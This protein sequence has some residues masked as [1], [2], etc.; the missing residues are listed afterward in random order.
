MLCVLALGK[1]GCRFPGPASQ[2]K[3][4]SKGLE[5]RDDTLIT[6]TYRHDTRE[7]LAHV[8]AQSRHSTNVLTFINVFLLSQL[9]FFRILENTLQIFQLF[10]EFKTMSD[11]EDKYWLWLISGIINSFSYDWGISSI[12]R[13]TLKHYQVQTLL[14]H[15]LYFL[16][17]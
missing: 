17:H 4:W 15:P 7:Y 12:F 9:W 16:W 1:I 6:D 10:R 3:I 14:N 11:L 8:L 5:L 2:E 13:A